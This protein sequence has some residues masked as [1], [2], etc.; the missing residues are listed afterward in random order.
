MP[1]AGVEPATFPLGGGRS[2]QLS[3][4]GHVP[5]FSH[6][7][8]EQAKNANR[9]A[10]IR[11]PV[12]GWNRSRPTAAVPQGVTTTVPRISDE[13]PGNEQKNV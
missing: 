8:K 6:A 11:G 3:Y 13:C 4:G 9:P 2:I 1:P 5:R 7:G 10:V 12:D